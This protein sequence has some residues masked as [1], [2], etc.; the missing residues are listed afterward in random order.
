M[1]RIAFQ[2]DHV[3]S[4]YPALCFCHL[5][6]VLLVNFCSIV[7]SPTSSFLRIIETNQGPELSD[8]STLGDPV[9]GNP[10]NMFGGQSNV[11]GDANLLQDDDQHNE[12]QS[13]AGYDYKLAYLGAG[14]LQSVSSAGGTKSAEGNRA[15]ADDLTNDGEAGSKVRF[16][17]SVDG[18]NVSGSHGDIS[19]F[20]EDNSFD[21]MYG[22]DERIEVIAPPGKLGVVI[23]TPMNGFPMVHAIKETSVLSDRVRIGDKLIAVDDEDTTEMSAIKVSKLISS[24]GSNPQRRMVFL[25]SPR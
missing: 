3:E 9:T 11:F 15:L 16:S 13:S 17:P 10:L 8:I 18:S 2:E 4:K 24:R 6:K 25:R 14:D 12:S 19:L 21:Q 20:E 23:D 22:E 1:I 5:Q 7:T